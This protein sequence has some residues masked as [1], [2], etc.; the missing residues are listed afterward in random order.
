MNN[1]ETICENGIS[2]ITAEKSTSDRMADEKM[3]SEETISEETTR[4]DW[5]EVYRL[6][7]LEVDGW[8]MPERISAAENAIKGRLQRMER[9]RDHQEERARLE[10]ALNAL[11]IVTTESNAWRKPFS[12]NPRY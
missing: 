8:K 12:A 9:D 4:E 3:I 1:Q 11:R 6:A 7:V 10:F 2:K 5:E